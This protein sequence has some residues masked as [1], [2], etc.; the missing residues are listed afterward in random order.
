MIIIPARLASTRF[1]NK[2]LAEID[3]K[4]M[5]IKTAEAA[6]TI[7]EVLIA[8]DDETVVKIAEEFGFNAVLTSK[9]HKSGTDRINEAAA[10]AGLSDDE[11]IINVQADEPF[12]ET[13]VIK[14]VYDL[15]KSNSLNS[16]ILMNSAYKIIDME[17]AQN[18]NIV[19][20]ITDASELALYFSRS[21]IPYPRDTHN[22][23][24]AHLGIYGFTR[25]ALSKFCSFSHAP[26][27]HIEKLEQ[28]RTLY[29][30]YKIA[31]VRVKSESIGI[32]TP[33]DLEKAKKRL[34]G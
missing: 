8:A 12:I 17:N 27:E 16:N 34:K 3:G 26:L 7:D 21:L 33:E 19:K 32:D 9:S 30:G 29:H 23:Y 20:V 2:V 11:I 5:V 1:P 15:T 13:D 31:M 28:L 22:E 4:P 14:A 6:S 18:P 25:K 24:K 10:R